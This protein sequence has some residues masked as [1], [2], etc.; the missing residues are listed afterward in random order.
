MKPSLTDK[1]RQSS[2]LVESHKTFKNDTIDALGETIL[3][4]KLYFENFEDHREWKNGWHYQYCC[5][6]VIMISQHDLIW[7]WSGTLKSSNVKYNLR[8]FKIRL[9]VILI[10]FNEHLTT[11]WKA[12]DNINRKMWRIQRM[13]WPVGW[14]VRALADYLFNSLTSPQFCSS[15][16]IKLFNGIQKHW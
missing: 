3:K 14:Y 12:L 6:W 7:V 2:S 5:P 9:Q 8:Y 11:V 13:C 10:D 4:V 15:S 16:N 1:A